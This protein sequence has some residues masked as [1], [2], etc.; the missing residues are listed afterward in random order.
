[1]IQFL[2]TRG[3]EYTHAP[4][5]RIPGA[6]RIGIM[7]YDRLIR[8]R[9]LPRASY[10]FTDIDRLSHGD[11][12]HAGRLYLELKA[13]GLRVFN[14][15]AIVK[16][17]YALLRALHVA[18]LNDF[19]AYR[20]D[21]LDRRVR[22]PVFLRNEH[23]HSGPLTDLL[24]TSDALR[25]AIDSAIAGGTP[26]AHLLAIE[27]AGEP[28]APGLYRKLAAFRLGD[29][30]VQHVSTH[31]TGWLMKNGTV[32]CGTEEIYQEE[33]GFIKANAFAEKLRKVFET[34]NIEYGRADFGFYQGR[35]QIFE[36]NTNPTITPPR[37]HP[38]AVR[39]ESRL[40]AWD[41]FVVGLRAL[42]SPGGWPV[43][44]VDGALQRKRPKRNLFFRTR[45]V[46]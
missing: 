1:M 22:Y 9:W 38:V 30:I 12:E 37:E 45:P 28:V 31:D 16:T 27:Y 25:Q 23:G 3:H 2:I 29:R 34:A 5:Q 15:P 8:S 35:M 46:A 39:R 43:R 7:G 11:L 21:E 19:N 17:R 33:N 42:D 13:A 36:I 26:A 32:G 41:N 10:I 14:N 44:I 40:I 20:M 4:L 6:P 24:P 18:G